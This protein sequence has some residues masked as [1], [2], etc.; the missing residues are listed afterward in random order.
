MK[1]S[2]PSDAV[3]AVLASGAA[4]NGYGLSYNDAALPAAVTAP[5]KVIG[6]PLCA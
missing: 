1:A 5:V 2:E 3:L 4:A 6:C